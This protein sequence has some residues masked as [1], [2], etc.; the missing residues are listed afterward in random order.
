MPKKSGRFFYW[1][2]ATLLMTGLLSSCGFRKKYENPITK[3]TQQPD[4][5][6]FDKA[7]NDIEKG[8]FDVARITL[9][10]LISTYDTSE[11]LAKAKLAIADSWFREGGA[12]GLAQAE[13]EYKEF[14]LFYP[15]L[16][17][18]PEAQE[19]VC[20]IHYRQMDK[21]DR[22]PDQALRAD[23]ECRQVLTQ[24]PNSKFAPRAEQILRNVQEVLA[25]HEFRVGDFYHTKGSFPAAAARFQGLADHY[26]LYSKADEALWKLADSYSRMPARFADRAAEA[27]AR[28]VRDY[29]LSAYA[30][31]ARQKLESLERPVPEAD[32]VA[33]ARMKYELA[34]QEKPG[35]MSHFWGIFRKSPNVAMAAK[36]GAPAM[37]ALRPAVPVSVPAPASGEAPTADVT[38]ATITGSSALDTQPDA[39][40]NP[41]GQAASTGQGAAQTE[42]LPTNQQPDPKKNQNSK[43]QQKKK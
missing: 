4:K 41:P 34:N 26:P 5:I 14:I 29:P 35:L 3:D 36:S 12:N 21:A 19:K 42:P 18:A 38:A 33:M 32:P 24:F 2:I 31:S 15:T 20:M 40:Q 25:A 10:T 6:L 30:D 27:Y 16:E 17:E 39:R 9:Q 7:V 22:D 8:R 23:E 43:K 13:A 28:I 11:Y 37:A 1:S